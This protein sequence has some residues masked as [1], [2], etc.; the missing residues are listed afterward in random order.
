MNC[1]PHINHIMR[2]V[3]KYS[4][5]IAYARAV[6][7]YHYSIW[8]KHGAWKVFEINFNPPKWT[9]CR[10]SS[11]KLMLQ[12]CNSIHRKPSTFLKTNNA[13]A[14]P[15]HRRNPL[16]SKNMVFSPL[17][18]THRHHIWLH[19]RNKQIE[20]PNRHQFL[21]KMQF[22]SCPFIKCSSYFQDC[23]ASARF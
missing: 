10:L 2:Q 1:L 8:S 3:T 9:M 7:I 19:K 14:H 16:R 5:T 21:V 22:S 20:Q 17:Q 13:Q 4:T 23:R 11:E 15:T 18:H 12:K 6:A